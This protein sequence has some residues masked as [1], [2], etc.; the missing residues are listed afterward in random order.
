MNQ[1]QTLSLQLTLDE[2]NLLLT[3]LGDRP[4][5]QVYPLLQKIQEQAGAQLRPEQ[6]QAAP[7]AAREVAV[8]ENGIT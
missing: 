7:V 6:E 8:E 4:Y 2:V 5:V 3:A 1:P